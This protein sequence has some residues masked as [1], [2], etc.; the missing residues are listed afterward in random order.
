VVETLGTHDAVGAADLMEVAPTY[1]DS[2]GTQ[3]LAAYLLVTLLER[4]FAESDTDPDTDPNAG[5]EVAS[6]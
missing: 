2:E 5:G 4:R 1:D 6:Q 3:R